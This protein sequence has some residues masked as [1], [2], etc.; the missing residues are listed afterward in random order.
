MRPSLGL[1]LLLALAACGRSSAGRPQAYPTPV[2]ATTAHAFALVEASGQSTC[3]AAADGST[4]CWGRNERGE[5]GVTA[6]LDTCDLSGIEL[7]PCTATPQPVAGLPAL[8]AI[9][10]G[11]SGGPSCGLGADG[12]AW[13]WGKGPGGQ[14]GD[15]LAHDSPTP[16][17]V[18]GD[19]RLASLRVSLTGL[20]ACG[21]TAAGEAW[22]WGASNGLFGDGAA[23]GASRSPT[24]VDRGHA[25]TQVELGEQHGCGLTAAGAAWCWG[26]NW[27]GQL[28]VGSA[29]GAGGVAS[30]ALPAQV[31][32][33]HAFTALS[34]ASDRT[35][36]LD[37]DGA[38]W[39][40]GNV[41]G[42]YAP[43]PQQVPGGHAYVAVTAGWTHAC[44]LTAAGEGWCWGQNAAGDLGDGT[45]RDAATPVR[46]Q[47]TAPLAA[48]SHRP[49]CALDRSGQAWCW[50]D[51]AYGQVG[52]ASRYAR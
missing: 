3:G 36:A 18:A 29:G 44:G 37:G 49:T 33:G 43:S 46:L 24:P 20:A 8:V 15:G 21:L 10:M 41:A 26:S 27:Y 35:C 7:V 40:W 28:G 13:C 47:V 34:T 16:V 45:T 23:G 51:D 22:C 14:L 25:F 6:P 30:S 48:L 42:A 5:L 31:V 2:V 39:C 52:R 17:V 1:P 9:S 50:G 19:Q 38:A 4:W 32:G 12:R 11:V